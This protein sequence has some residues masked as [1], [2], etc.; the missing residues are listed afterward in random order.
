[1][2]ATTALDSLRGEVQLRLESHPAREWS[3]RLL[4]A[5]IAIFDLEFGEPSR[6]PNLRLVT[7]PNGSAGGSLPLAGVVEAEKEAGRST[8]YEFLD[9]PSQSWSST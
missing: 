8:N 6:P 5:L 1:M 2:T 3:P 9:Q 7:L 4:R